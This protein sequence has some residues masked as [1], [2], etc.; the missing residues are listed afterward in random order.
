MSTARI[1]CYARVRP[2]LAREVAG[3]DGGLLHRCVGAHPQFPRRI[4]VSSDASR[5]VLVH[6]D[7]SVEG[8]G[9]DVRC[10]DLDAVF[11]EARDTEGVYASACSRTVAGALDGVN[12]SILC[13]GMTSSGKT[14][15]ML[16]DERHCGIVGM[17]AQQLLD[18]PD[19][20]VEVSFMQL[21]GNTPTD[22]L[23]EV[24]RGGDE[25][26]G[27]R[28]TGGRTVGGRSSGGGSR[29]S[30]GNS[31]GSSS[32]SSGRSSGRPSGGAVPSSVPKLVLRSMDRGKGTR[33]TIVEGLSRHAVGSA[34]EVE[35]LVRAGAARRATGKQNLNDVSS[36]SHAVLTFYVTRTTSSAMRTEYNASAKANANVNDDAEDDD[37]VYGEGKE[38]KHGGG[39]RD[40]DF[41]PK[42]NDLGGDEG[43]AVVTTAKL[44]CV[45]LAGSE[46]VKESG[47]A[48][49]AL[50]EARQIN[51][52][53]FHLIRVVHALNAGDQRVPYKESALTHLLQVMKFA[54]NTTYYHGRGRT[55]DPS[56]LKHRFCTNRRR[57]DLNIYSNH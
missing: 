50:V 18:D 6:A 32:G 48:G 35:R 41:P 38:G 30:S 8:E 26:A 31:S 9:G 42:E 49:Q 12:G 19:S 2:A 53:L 25:R 55:E 23:H 20:T 46:R 15:T 56:I 17:A 36:R 27:G 7:G 22:L 51:L 45:D 28:G 3:G 33:E 5:P 14:H 13:Y 39:G 11:D 40:G 4:F 29:R 10:Y 44:H 57:M 43:D 47:V 24:R 1:R 21:Y 37:D 52:S 34:A 16:G 54:L